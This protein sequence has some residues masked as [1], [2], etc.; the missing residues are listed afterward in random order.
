MEEAPAVPAPSAA[1]SAAMPRAAGTTAEGRKGRFPM[2][3]KFLGR[4]WETKGK[5]GKQM[6]RKTNLSDNYDNF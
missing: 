6:K 4:F 5:N 1:P 3:G 2:I